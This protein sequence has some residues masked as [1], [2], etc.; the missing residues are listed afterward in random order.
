MSA[1]NVQ[2]IPLASEFLK[3]QLVAEGVRASNIANAT[4]PNYLAKEPTFEMKLDQA[5]RAAGLPGIKYEMRI[6]RSDDAPGKEGNNVK[7]EKEMTALVDHS[8]RYMTAIKII[9]KEFA[10]AQYAAV[11]GGR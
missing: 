6:N 8:L 9:S 5:A 3:T 7:I 1:T 10:I 11:Q 4:T 2:L